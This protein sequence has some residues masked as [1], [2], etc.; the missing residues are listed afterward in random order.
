MLILSNVLELISIGAI[1]VF[2]SSIYDK[3]YFFELIK[4]FNLFEIDFLNEFDQNNLVFYGAL[5]LIFIFVI[6][7]LFLAV[8]IFFRYYVIKNIRSSFKNRVLK[9]NLSKDYLNFVNKNSAILLREINL[10]CGNASVLIFSYTNLIK[11]I[12]L[13]VLIFISLSIF[14]LKVSIVLLFFFLIFI[15]IFYYIF[16]KRIN[17]NAE[18]IKSSASSLNKIINQIYGSIKDII[19]YDL[20]K[21]FKNFNNVQNEMENKILFNNFI[22]SFPR[23]YL[24][25]LSVISLML[26]IILF[27][28]IKKIQQKFYFPYLFLQ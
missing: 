15:S 25:I 3:E 28:I 23:I 26:I 14:D 18:I 17:R 19:I 7:N 4:K 5:I 6:K 16:K 2:L 12:I 9:T 22:S 1:P 10:D 8:I 20:K 13:L 11:E 27:W 21:N 24:E